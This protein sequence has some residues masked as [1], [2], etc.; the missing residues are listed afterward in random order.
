[1]SRL[2]LSTY[3][4]FPALRTRQAELTG[5]KQLDDARKAR[6]VPMLTLGQWR[7]SSELTRAAEKAVDAI[8]GRPFFMDL[9]NDNRKVEA[10]WAQLRDS[11]TAFK[12]WRDFAAEYDNAFPVV[13]MPAGARLRDVVQQAQ[14]IE[15]SY[16]TVAFRI[17][18]FGSQTSLVLSAVSALDDPGNAIVFIDCQYIRDSLAAF[19][20]ATIATINAL[21]SEFPSLL[22]VVLSTSF[23]SSTIPFADAS[24]Q[25]GVISILERELYERAGGQAAALYGDHG[26][27][28]SVV[29]DDV[30]M[31]RWSPRIDFPTYTHWHFERRPGAIEAGFIEAARAIQAEFDCSTSSDIW[32]ERMIAQ[33]AAGRPYGKAPASWISVRVNI[34]LSRQIDFEAAARQEDD[35]DDFD[36]D[37]DNDDLR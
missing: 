35:E 7:G 32:G 2:E 6:I 31:M 4:Y 1:M 26:S 11:T 10:H 25:R 16:G 19:V 36:F 8:G 21:R 30:P 9:S 22:I 13:Q 37:N 33:A 3:G 24:K 28:H 5:L 34:H 23:P 12:A 20:T 14:E 18:D 27:I 17:Q 15:S 29:Y